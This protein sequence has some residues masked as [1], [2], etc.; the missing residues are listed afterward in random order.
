LEQRLAIMSAA[1][2]AALPRPD[3]GVRDE[4]SMSEPTESLTFLN[5]IA[6]LATR[7]SADDIVIYSLTYHCLAFG[8]WEL[9]AGRRRVRIQ[10]NWEGKDR[11]LRVSTAQMIAGSTARQWQLVEDHDFRKRRVDVTLLLGTVHAA[12]TAHAGV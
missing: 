4:P 8:S 12:I 11:H 9:E 1:R 7:L 5:A 6:Q 2:G 3:A 10:V